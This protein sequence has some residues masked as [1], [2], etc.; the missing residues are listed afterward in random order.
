MI[1]TQKTSSPKITKTQLFRTV[2]SS[3]AIET[4]ISVEEIEQQ[5]K[6]FQAQAKAVG[7]AR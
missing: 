1:T 2:A 7:L 3:T 6:R 5:L 4:G